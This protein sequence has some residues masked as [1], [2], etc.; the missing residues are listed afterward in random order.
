MEIRS[1][2]S[3]RII[4]ATL[5]V[6]YQLIDDRTNAKP[7]EA[8]DYVVFEYCPDV[9]DRRWRICGRVHESDHYFR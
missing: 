3:I 5:E 1:K 4:Q 6:P 7:I 8:K 2:G 9:F